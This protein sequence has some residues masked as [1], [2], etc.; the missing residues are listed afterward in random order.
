MNKLIGRGATSIILQAGWNVS[1]AMLRGTQVA[2]LHIHPRFS[3]LGKDLASPNSHTVFSFIR[4]FSLHSCTNI[5][6]NWGMVLIFIITNNIHDFNLQVLLSKERIK[7]LRSSHDIPSYSIIL[8]STSIFYIYLFL[9][10]RTFRWVMV[11]DLNPRSILWAFLI[12]Y[13][14]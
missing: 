14:A 4:G 11:E 7:K 6:I 5:D 12:L 2:S 10:S 1:D 13:L 3:I 9:L 8:S